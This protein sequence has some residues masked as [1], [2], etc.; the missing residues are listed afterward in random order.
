MAVFRIEKARDFTVM[1][2]HHLKNRNLTLKAKGLL[3]MIFSLPDDWHY[4]TRGLASICKEGV[5]SISGAIKELERP[6]ISSA[7]ACGTQRAAS[8]IRNMSSTKRPFQRFPSASRI[9]LSR[10]RLHQI[11]KIRIW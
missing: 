8:L 10:I 9:W 4:T 2:N 1:S 5:D 7:I 6:G 3:S 11:R